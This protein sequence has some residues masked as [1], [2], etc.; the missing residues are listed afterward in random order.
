MAAPCVVQV[1]KPVGGN[2]IEYRKAYKS[3]R[4]QNSTTYKRIARL[5]IRHLFAD[6]ATEF[7]HRAPRR[8]TFT[9]FCLYTALNTPQS[10]GFCCLPTR[11]SRTA[12][13]LRTARD[14]PLHE[15]YKFRICRGI[16]VHG[17]V[18]RRS[19]CPCTCAA[20]PTD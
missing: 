4:F 6:S 11:K 20:L 14:T 15:I 19:A 9:R 10:T 17:R 18:Y 1:M 2:I 12:E 8:R 5:R 13:P 16:R 3:E 7:N